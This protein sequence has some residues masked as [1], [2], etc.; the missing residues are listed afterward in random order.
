MDNGTALGIDIVIPAQKIAF[1][2]PAVEI[3]LIPWRQEREFFLNRSLFYSVYFYFKSGQKSQKLLIDPADFI[4][5]G[6]VYVK[7][8]SQCKNLC[9]Y[10]IADVFVLIINIIGV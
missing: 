7:L 8:V 5:S 1:H 3:Y 4:V 2:A 6:I 9:F 10:K